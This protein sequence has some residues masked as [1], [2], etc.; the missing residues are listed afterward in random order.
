MAI[1]FALLS[2]E[3]IGRELGSRARVRRLGQNLTLEGLAARSGV[4]FG[5][6][7]VRAHRQDIPCLVRPPRRRLERRSGPR[8]PPCRAGVRDLGPGTEIPDKAQARADP[9]KLAAG[10]PLTVS[11]R[12]GAQDAQTVG[13][14]AFRDGLAYLEDDEGFLRDGLGP[15][16]VPHKTGPGLVRPHDRAVFNGLH[17]VFADSLPD[18]G[19]GCWLTGAPANSSSSPRP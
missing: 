6:Q 2:S 19:A 1:S 15:S 9:M 4:A 8:W 10:A 7:E 18:G 5:T 12:W 17:G 11:L 3:E 16:P 14:L 13:R